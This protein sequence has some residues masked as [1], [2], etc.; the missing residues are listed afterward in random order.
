MLCVRLQHLRQELDTKFYE[1]RFDWEQVRHNDAAG[2][3]KMF[4]REL[5]HPLL[6]QQHMP[7]F[8]AAQ[9]KPPT[10]NTLPFLFLFIQIT[11]RD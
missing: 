7:A 1:D 9:S 6:T 8:T 10:H 3:L 11:A 4:I 5:P 2:L